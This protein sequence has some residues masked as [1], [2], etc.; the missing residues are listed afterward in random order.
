MELKSSQVI[1]TD[2]PSMV[3]SDTPEGE[4]PDYPE[5][6]LEY[7]F[8]IENK[9]KKIGDSMQ[10]LQVEFEPDDNLVKLLGE[11][12]FHHNPNNGMAGP[13]S[14]EK[15]SEGEFVLVFGLAKHILK[16]I[17]K[18]QMDELLQGT[19]IVKEGEKRIMQLPVK[20]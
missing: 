2:T 13:A 4:E 7:T 10:I 20:K 9:G 14:L 18:D 6:Y 12:I 15:N 3:N 19:L 11:D 8:L 16:E 5:Y 1:V 17:D